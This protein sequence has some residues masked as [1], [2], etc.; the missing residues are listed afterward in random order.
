MILNLL[1]VFAESPRT[2]STYLYDKTD[3]VTTGSSNYDN[4]TESASVPGGITRAELRERAK[5]Y[6]KPVEPYCTVEL[7]PGK[8]DKQIWHVSA[9]TVC[10]FIG[11]SQ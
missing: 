10:L 11:N 6:T 5:Q 9:G 7:S 1:C 3:D 4:N 2:T 8:K